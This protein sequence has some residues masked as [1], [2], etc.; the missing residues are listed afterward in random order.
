MSDTPVYFWKLSSYDFNNALFFLFS[1]PLKKNMNIANSGLIILFYRVNT[2]N[3][4]LG[5]MLQTVLTG[6]APVFQSIRVTRYTLENDGVASRDC[7][8]FP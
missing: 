3:Q 4:C 5:D 8:L 7:H 1:F 2:Q 6:K